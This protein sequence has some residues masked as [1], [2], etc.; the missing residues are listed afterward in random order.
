MSNQ[1]SVGL[2]AYDPPA[3]SNQRFRVVIQTDGNP[4]KTEKTGGNMCKKALLTLAML[5][6]AGMMSFAAGDKD[7]V[8]VIKEGRI[9]IVIATNRVQSIPL[10]D[11]SDANLITIFSN[12]A[13]YPKG[14]YWAFEGSPVNG[15]AGGF[16]PE[17]WRAAAFTPRANH[18]ATVVKVAA[19]WS[20]GTNGLVLSLNHD[21]NGVPG[22]AIETW[23]LKNLPEFGTC[24][25]VKVRTDGVGIPLT[26]ATQYWIVLSTNSAEANTSAV[27][28]FNDTDQVDSFLEAS[29]CPANCGF[30]GAG[31][32]AYESYSVTGSGLAYA[33]LGS[34]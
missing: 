26:A 31:W 7:R 23:Q 13:S 22:N 30:G 11:S 1:S 25:E 28:V 5:G 14:K 27:W 17:N 16:G 29:Y 12:L 10:A 18:T 8:I 34:K 15:P 33:V 6:L 2:L 24:C 3:S 20:S 32:Q 19:A 4:E 21:A 9:P